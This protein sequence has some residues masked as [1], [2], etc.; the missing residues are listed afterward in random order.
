MPN[1][2]NTLTLSRIAA[3]PLIAGLLFLEQP[4]FRWSALILFAIA[5]ITDFFDGYIARRMDQVSALGRFLDPIADKLVVGAIL[6][7]LVATQQVSGWSVLP[8]LIIMCREIMVSGLREYLAELKVGVP[9][10]MLAKWKTTAQML[11]LGFL[12]VGSAGPQWLPVVEIGDG[13]LWLAAAL[14]VVTG[15]D[16]LRVGIRHM[17]DDPSARK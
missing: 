9:V 15:Y 2:A 16:Y 14:T 17:A 6:M 4:V 3:I 11:A 13:L 8:A 10:T 5:C 12:I 1:I 7:A